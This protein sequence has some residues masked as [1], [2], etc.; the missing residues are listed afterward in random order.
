LNI[1]I[2]IEDIFSKEIIG[3][4]NPEEAIQAGEWYSCDITRKELKTFLK[5]DNYHAILDFFYLKSGFIAVKN[6]ILHSLGIPSR[7]V[8]SYVTQDSV[9]D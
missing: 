4:I 5:R 9:K 8:K 2:I 7:I 1:H 3:M 6:L